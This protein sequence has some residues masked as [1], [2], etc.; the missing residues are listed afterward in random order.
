[1]NTQKL[2]QLVQLAGIAQAFQNDPAQQNQLRRDLMQ[3][4]L[5]F[6][7]EMAELDR[8]REAERF[9]AE[10]ANVLADRSFTGE[11][12]EAER[13]IRLQQ[14]AAAQAA[15]EQEQ[16]GGIAGMLAEQGQYEEALST[17]NPNFGSEYRER[18][19]G[20]AAPGMQ[21]DLERMY[22]GA[23]NMRELSAMLGNQYEEVANDPYMLEAYQTLMPWDE[24]NQGVRSLPPGQQRPPGEWGWQDVANTT[25]RLTGI[26]GLSH[27]GQFMTDTGSRLG[28]EA[29]QGLAPAATKTKDK[30]SALLNWLTN[31]ELAQERAANASWNQTQP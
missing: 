2:Q 22:S 17:L 4:E 24:L 12:N 3:E 8:A 9:M 26:E 28:G 29:L 19:V 11:Q 27:I 20:R 5:Q 10:Q 13:Q 1:M 21:R 18:Q 7:R 25:N 16:L 6:R 15:S 30:I 31:P 14:I 23:K